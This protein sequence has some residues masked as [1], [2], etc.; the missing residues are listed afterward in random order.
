MQM[1]KLTHEAESGNSLKERIIFAHMMK[2][3]GTSVT[4]KFAERFGSR[5][6]I[7]RG[8]LPLN[9]PDGDIFFAVNRI[10]NLSPNVSVISGHDIRPHANLETINN[11]DFNWITFLREPVARFISHFYYDMYRS[12]GFVY[13]KYQDMQSPTLQEWERIDQTRNYQTRFIAGA[14]NVD[15]AI[16]ILEGFSFVG[17]CEQFP[18]SLMALASSLHIDG[19]DW[20]PIQKNKRVPARMKAKLKI[21]KEFALEANASDILLYNYVLE[22]IWPRFRREARRAA[23]RRILN[24]VSRKSN[25]IRF[26]VARAANNNETDFTLKNMKRFARRWF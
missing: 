24:P 6:H 22:H 18:N 2:T 19:F 17:I 16:S 4:K 21:D 25:E 9:L 13:K 10:V 20:R 1:S 7:T 15:K 14:D 3:A 12:K 23:D 8:G 5:L 26:L 11:N